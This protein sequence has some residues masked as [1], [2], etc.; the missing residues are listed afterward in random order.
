MPLRASR[1]ACGLTSL[2][3]R[4]TSGSMRQALELSIT[5][6]PA[7]A[8]RGAC[9]RLPVAPAENRAMSMPDGS[10]VST[11]SMM[12]VCPA[13]S[14]AVPAERA[15]ANRRSSRIGKARSARIS[16]MT[17]PTWPVAPTT[18]TESPESEMRVMAVVLECR[19]GRADAIGARDSPI[20]PAPLGTDRR[21]YLP[22][23][24]GARMIPAECRLRPTPARPPRTTRRTARTTGRPCG[25]SPRSTSAGMS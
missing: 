10:A 16:R 13:N 15:V 9:A 18:A 1:I 17:V 14:T 12:T 21:C 3:T 20:L 4:G 23:T 2:T 5:V 8:K 6:A 25:M 19:S 7:S 22:R 24:A 11:S